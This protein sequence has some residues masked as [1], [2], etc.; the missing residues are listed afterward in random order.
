VRLV[1]FIGPN[2]LEHL[3][4]ALLQLERPSEAWSHVGGSGDGGVDGMGADYEGRVVGL[5]QC[6]WSYDGHELPFAGEAELDRS[7]ERFVATLVHTP[8]LNASR[9]T[10]LL[11]RPAIAEL[12]LKHAHTL[13]WARTMRIASNA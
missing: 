3:V 10:R 8:S 4:V 2:T 9:G 6:K 1:S 5:L 13:P 7:I 12:V 11:D